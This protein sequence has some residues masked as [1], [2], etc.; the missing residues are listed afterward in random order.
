[1]KAQVMVHNGVQ[2][3]SNDMMVKAWQTFL[4]MFFAF[5]E[6][7]YAR[8]DSYY[9]YILVNMEQFYPDLKEMISKEDILIQGQEKYALRTE[10]DQ[11]GEQSINRVAKTSGKIISIVRSLL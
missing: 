3:N 7:N 2:E 8:Y 11:R 10:I 1:M 6:V 9:T 4:S 5:N